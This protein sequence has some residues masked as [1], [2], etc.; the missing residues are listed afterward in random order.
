MRTAPRKPRELA[1]QGA[2]PWA[3]CLLLQGAFSLQCWATHPTLDSSPPEVLSPSQPLAPGCWPLPSPELA[4]VEG[5]AAGGG[6]T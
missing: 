5:G 4:L 6:A 2:G 3:G 1:A